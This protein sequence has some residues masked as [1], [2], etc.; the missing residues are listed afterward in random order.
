MGCG[1]HKLEKCGKAPRHVSGPDSKHSLGA[2][3]LPSRRPPRGP[4]SNRTGSNPAGSNSEQQANN[5]QTSH[6]CGAAERLTAP[7]CG[8]TLPG[9]KRFLPR[10]WEV[11][12]VR[13]GIGFIIGAALVLA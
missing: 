6:S 9:S 11:G 4:V 10:Y 12:R 3:P 8:S 5:T 7:K 1:G 2:C 13:R